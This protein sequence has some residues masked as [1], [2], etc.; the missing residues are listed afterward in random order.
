MNHALITYHNA[1]ADLNVF[2]TCIK[3]LRHHSSCFIIVF[4]D[5]LDDGYI[6]YA[7]E[8]YSVIFEKVP[9]MDGERAYQKIKQYCEYSCDLD[10]GEQVAVLDADLLFIDNPFKAFEEYNI[11]PGDIGLTERGYKYWSKINGGVIFWSI[12][13]GIKELLKF[14][15]EQSYEPTWNVYQKYQETFRHVRYGRDWTRGQDFLNTIYLNEDKVMAM[16]DEIAILTISN[17]Y[18]FCPAVDL[19]GYEKSIAMMIEE[20]LA[21]DVCVLHLKSELKQLIYDGVFIEA[22]TKHERGQAKWR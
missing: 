10:D 2:E 6:K 16:F 5:D 7:S 20:Y 9:P 11:Q 12:N 3:T 8:K 1:G 19:F 13:D 4:T 21:K 14:H 18:N 17:H 15:Q 22:V